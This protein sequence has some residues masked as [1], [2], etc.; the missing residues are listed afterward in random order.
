MG[1]MLKDI[2]RG[3]KRHPW[4]TFRDAFLAFS[5]MWTITEG[6]SYFVPGFDIRGYYSLFGIAAVSVVFAL[7]RVAKPTRIEIK[8]PYTDTVLEI[9]FGDLFGLEGYRAIS[10]NEFFDSDLGKIVAEESLH[11]Q[12]LKKCFG[13]HP[14]SFDKQVT[15]ELTNVPPETTN[16]SGGKTLRYPVGTSALITVD[17]ERYLTFVLT[18]TDLETHKAS[19]DV[20]MLWRGLQGLWKR[21]RIETGGQSLNVP[22]VGSGLAGIGLPTRDLLNLILLSAIAETKQKQITRRIRVVLWKD[23]YDDLDLRDVKRYWEEL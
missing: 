5:A 9:I 8:I 7:Y 10:V 22:L 20:D 1:R 15:D 12:F 18:Q 13:G 11:G 2:Y 6:L 16:R 23:R 21:A 4:R 3:I 19:A 14:E 17:K